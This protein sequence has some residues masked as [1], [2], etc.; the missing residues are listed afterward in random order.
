MILIAAQCVDAIPRVH[1]DPFRRPRAVVPMCVTSRII[2]R[3]PE[4]PCEDSSIDVASATVE[5]LARRL[6]VSQPCHYSR[7]PSAFDSSVIV[8]T[9]L[10]TARTSTR[11]ITSSTNLPSF[12]TLPDFSATG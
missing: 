6:R 8:G 5:E 3:R 4:K 2:A 10:S 1:S 7:Y 9:S 12:R 11:E